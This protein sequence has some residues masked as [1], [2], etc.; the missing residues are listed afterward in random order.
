MFWVKTIFPFINKHK[1]TIL[2]SAFLS[3][4]LLLGMYILLYNDII[5]LQEFIGIS[6]V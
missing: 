3:I 2:F 5:I 4:Y 6:L 1:N